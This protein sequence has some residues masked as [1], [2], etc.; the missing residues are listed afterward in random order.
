MHERVSSSL[1]V[2]QTR[3]SFSSGDAQGLHQRIESDSESGVNTSEADDFNFGEEAGLDTDPGMYDSCTGQK[4]L[5]GLSVR[6]NAQLSRPCAYS[7]LKELFQAEIGCACAILAACSTCWLCMC[8][9][10]CV[11][12]CMRV[13]VRAHT[14]VCACVCNFSG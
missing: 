10:V 3:G 7:G 14:C 4:R 12:V 13:C 1:D 2:S 11:C 5:L 8:V 6:F 9:C